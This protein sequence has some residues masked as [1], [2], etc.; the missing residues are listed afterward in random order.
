MRLSFE[1]SKHAWLLYRGK[2]Y[3]VATISSKLFK[4]IVTTTCPYSNRDPLFLQPETDQL[5]R[6]Y[7]L[8]R[9][10]VKLYFLKKGL[11]VDRYR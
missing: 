1:E 3:P 11:F 9:H 7:I 4:E 8:L 10:P 2:H 6:W 5:E